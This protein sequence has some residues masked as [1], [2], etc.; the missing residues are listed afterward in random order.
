MIERRTMGYEQVYDFLIRKLETEL[1]VYLTYHTTEHTLA[2]IAATE[3][4]A[5]GEKI[6]DEELILLKTAALFH[7]AGFLQQSD[8]HE[9]ISCLLAREYLPVYGYNDNQVEQVCRMI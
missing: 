9:E 8:G 6:G 5:V 1:P 3:H 4:L 7:D 2:V